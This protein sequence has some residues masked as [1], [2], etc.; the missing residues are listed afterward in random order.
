MS[1]KPCTK[2]EFVEII[3]AGNYG[4]TISRDEIRSIM[5]SNP[6][7]TWPYWLT[8]ASVTNGYYKTGIDGHYKNPATVPMVRGKSHAF[9]SAAAPVRAA[10]SAKTEVS[11]VEPESGNFL[12]RVDES[13]VPFGFFRDLETIIQSGVF[14]P[15]Y[16]TGL[17]GNGKTFAVEQACAKLGREM[18]RVNLT[19]ETDI[20]DL[21]GGFR[22][23]DG[24]TVWQDGP[25]VVAML[26]G[27][28]LLL[29]EIDLASI[30]IMCLQSVIEK[31]EVFIK[32]TSRFVKAAPGF[33]IVATANTKG[34]GS[35]DGKFIGAGI[36]NESFLERFQFT[37]EH[38]YPEERVERAILSKLVSKESLLDT[39]KVIGTLV[40]WA[41]VI[42]DSYKANAVDDVISTRRLTHIIK[43]INIFGDVSKPLAFCLNRF[44]DAT[45]ESFIDLYRK[46][47][48]SVGTESGDAY[49]DTHSGI[50]RDA[51]GRA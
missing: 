32:K 38:D 35:A 23:V 9:A 46:V 15:V 14:A 49:Q 44:D 37:F 39:A 25:V 29:D 18:I 47:D 8:T 28:V 19:I 1:Y 16:I 34:R 17:S 4:E 45:K 50:N 11:R 6:Q 3:R 24:N 42:R 33:Q 41:N 43:G 2:E 21:I 36:M 13:F 26:R 51:T 20:D 30:K 7:L 5:D 48:G 27:A 12:V 22:L 10:Q 40:K 31:G